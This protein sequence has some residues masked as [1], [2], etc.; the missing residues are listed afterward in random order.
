MLAKPTFMAPPAYS[1]QPGS[2]TGF[3]N[4]G[5]DAGMGITTASS[6][7]LWRG[8]AETASNPSVKVNVVRR[9]NP[10]TV[11]FPADAQFVFYAVPETG[12]LDFTSGTKYSVANLNLLLRERRGYSRVCRAEDVAATFRPGGV[13][14]A[15]GSRD[16]QQRAQEGGAKLSTF[17]PAGT[18]HAIA[19]VWGAPNASDTLFFQLWP[20]A[21]E[22]KAV[23][24]LVEPDLA[25]YIPKRARR[26]LGPVDPFFGS[27]PTK[28]PGFA[29]Q[30]I[31]VHSPDNM[32]PPLPPALFGPFMEELEE[33]YGAPAPGAR[34]RIHAAFYRHLQ[35]LLS[36]SG[37]EVRRYIQAALDEQMPP[38]VSS[39]AEARVQRECEAATGVP[40]NAGEDLT[41]YLGRC[42]TA[43]APV[44]GPLQESMRA[45]R[46]Y[47]N[48]RVGKFCVTMARK[49]SVLGERA[50]DAIRR[51]AVCPRSAREM[52]QALLALP[53]IS[54]TVGMVRYRAENPCQALWGT[55]TAPKP[56]R[57]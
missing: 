35:S 12:D 55:R 9:P 33:V 50:T 47:I 52:V 36:G 17:D 48:V 11:A 54:V 13:C 37:D 29:W 56:M 39:A 1:F 40:R 34:A 24:Q 41:T 7:R 57:S 23:A 27:P 26:E 31:P 21:C 46:M 14:L 49:K 38:T 28:R 30:F 51:Q 4:P 10:D 3:V 42:A 53:T 6:A 15:D 19:D 18:A 25:S 44:R 32:P 20:V 2:G 43:Y 5:I 8:E 45:G 16:A 22:E